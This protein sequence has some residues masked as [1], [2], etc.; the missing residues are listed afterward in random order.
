MN[1][2]TEH[3]ARHLSAADSARKTARTPD[4]RNGRNE[5]RGSGM[6]LRSMIVAAA[7]ASAALF[8]ASNILTDANPD[9]LGGKEAHTLALAPISLGNPAAAATLTTRFP[10]IPGEEIVQ[11]QPY[12]FIVRPKSGDTLAQ[13]LIRAG[14]AA[15]AAHRAVGAMGKVFSARRIRIGQDIAVSFEPG[16]NGRNHGR[17]LGFSLHPSYDQV[18]EVW[19]EGVDG[20]RASKAARDLRHDLAAA[21][22][23]IE[24]SL[25]VDGTRSGIPA[26]VLVELIR[27]YSWD[28][29]FQ[30][31]IRKGDR[32]EVMYEQAFD[33]K[34]RL[35]NN[36]RIIF[37]A[38]TLSGENKPMFLF[39]GDKGRHEH[40]NAKGHGAKKAL[41][42]TPI[43][44]ARLSSGFG[45]R[46]HPILSYTRMHKGI[47]FAA[48]PGTPIYAGGDGV[49]NYRGRKGSYGNYIRIRHTNGYSTAYAHMSRFKRGVTKGTRV[50]Q[51]QVIGYVGS[52]GRSTGPHLHYEI[53]VNGRHTNPLKVKM[54]SGRKLTGEEL[55]R[56]LATK[57]DLER[58]YAA[59]VPEARIT[60]APSR[61]VDSR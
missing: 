29:D 32:F 37:A 46:R 14:A 55:E 45:R 51:G 1:L 43:N 25:Y 27:I 35:V 60:Q 23:T 18:V 41:L 58:R 28:V 48:P 4:G 42:R 8:S 20:F 21:R 39:K 15:D 33:A 17:F 56:F 44:G 16:G 6:L 47:D 22:G 36:G 3:P 30:R 59:L 19:R 57:T 50:R 26:A 38:L 40:F 49:V 7:A 54:P 5:G 52:T 13:I 61:R 34:G 24:S 53:L 9:T 12:D 11:P 31:E 10:S 2:D